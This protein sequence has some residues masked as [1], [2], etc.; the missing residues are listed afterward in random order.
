MN[1]SKKLVHAEDLTYWRYESE[2]QVNSAAIRAGL[3][4]LKTQGCRDR[5]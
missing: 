4:I 3:K 5:A 2:F 1:Y